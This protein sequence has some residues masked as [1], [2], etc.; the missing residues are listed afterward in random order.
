VLI[1]PLDNHDVSPPLTELARLAPPRDDDE[2]AEAEP[3]RP[4]PHPW[5]STAAQRPD[6]VVQTA[7]GAADAPTLI[8]QFEGMGAGLPGFQVAA[9]PPDTDGDIG[10]SH[11]VQIVNSSLAIFNRAGTVVLG[12]MLTKGLW[13]GFN[14]ACA[15]TNDGDGVVRYDRIADRWVISQFSVNGGNG[16][17]FQCVAV[18]TTADPTGSYNR[19][20]FTFDNFND[21]PKMGL[22]PDAYYFTF[23]MFM[24]NNF[25]GSRVCAFDRTKMLAGMTATEQC[26]DTSNQFGG[27]LPSDLDGTTMPPAG[28]PNF[29]VAL[30]VTALD[31]WT[32]HVDFATPANSRFTGPTTIPVSAFTPLCNGGTCV[33]QPGTTQR[34]DSLADRLMNR[35]VYRRFADHEALLVSHSVAAGAGGGVRW[36][37]LR[38]PSTTPVMFQQ[39]TYAPDSAYRWM[40]SLAFDSGGDIGLAFS[41][42]SSTINPGIR[43]TGRLATDA[44]GTMGQGEAV[45]INGG[46]S[47][48]GMN[49]SRWGDYSAMSIDP[50]DDCTFWYT[51]EYAAANGAFNWHTRVAAFTLGLSTTVAATSLPIAIPDNDP[52][53]ITSS[54][55]VVGTGAIASLSLSLNITHPFR[56]DLVITLISP[57]GTEFIVSGRQGGN[58]NNLSLTKM[59]IPAFNGQSLAGTWQLKIADL[60]IADTGTLDSWSLTLVGSCK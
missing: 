34:L 6:P 54:I 19:Y 36:Y 22:W 60:A 5:L 18:S 31:F 28:A 55:P 47:Q 51:Q 12:P 45:L 17:F 21:Y 35:L 10:P 37:E 14:G 30:D 59:A 7:P 24:N 8:T 39:G 48:Q 43:F 3:I 15:S 26:F 33:Q 56:G 42:S 58:A 13:S 23:N 46:G 2:V 50:T 27:L 4:I 11:Y 49:L 38:A 20:Q 41:T 57:D 16:P 53:G 44:P 52:L 32:F 1:I 40:S 9:A 25:N 29:M